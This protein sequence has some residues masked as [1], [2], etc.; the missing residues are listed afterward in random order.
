MPVGT[1]DTPSLAIR[2]LRQ[3]S[4]ARARCPRRRRTE[5]STAD[6]NRA[7][8]FGQRRRWRRSHF[9]LRQDDPGARFSM[10]DAGRRQRRYRALQGVHLRRQRGDLTGYFSQVRLLGC[11]TLRERHQH[12]SVLLLRRDNI[13]LRQLN[14]PQR[15]ADNGIR[16]PDRSR[17]TWRRCREATEIRPGEILREIRQREAARQIETWQPEEIGIREGVGGGRADDGQGKGHQDRRPP[18]R[19]PLLRHLRR[20]VVLRYFIRRF[21]HLRPHVSA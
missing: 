21:R 15:R 10:R 18:V 4:C 5:R 7:D 11:S 3:L 9:S 2:C 14:I 1:P 17:L 13:L 19:R 20:I 12:G 6:R 16:Y 8:R